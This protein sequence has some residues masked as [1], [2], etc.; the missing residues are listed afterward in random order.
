[1]MKATLALRINKP[2]KWKS[3]DEVEDKTNS[4]QQNYHTYVYECTRN[5]MYRAEHTLT[6]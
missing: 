1:M 5:Y 4:V 2:N 3:D 6:S